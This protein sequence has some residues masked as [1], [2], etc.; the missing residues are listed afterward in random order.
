MDETA[1][2]PPVRHLL[3][4]PPE[5]FTFVATHLGTRDLHSTGR[6][7]HTLHEW[8]VESCRELWRSV[9]PGSKPIGLANETKGS[10]SGS[11][12]HLSLVQLLR[13]HPQHVST[14]SCG[15]SATPGAAARLRA[16]VLL[17]KPE[18][19][20]ESTVENVITALQAY[21]DALI[22]F[23]ES[24]VA[25]LGLRHAPMLSRAN[26][27]EIRRHFVKDFMGEM[28]DEHETTADLHVSTRELLSSYLIRT[29]DADN[30]HTK[31]LRWT[32][33]SRA[34]RPPPHCIG[35][36][37]HESARAAY[38][39]LA[40]VFC[41]GVCPVDDAHFRGALSVARASVH[42]RGVAFQ[43]AAQLPEPDIFTQNTLHNVAV[44]GL[45]GIKGWWR[46]VAV[47]I[48]KCSARVEERDDSIGVMASPRVF[49]VT[50][51][52]ETMDV[53]RPG[54]LVSGLISTRLTKDAPDSPVTRFVDT[55]EVWP[56]WLPSS[57]CASYGDRLV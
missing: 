50:F 49:D 23:T 39:C 16:R 12:T 6:A 57:E 28:V 56:T 41:F 55:V 4:L 44:N 18:L 37:M 53:V 45:E 43:L 2:P 31:L 51:L 20:K 26:R 27:K 25:E 3:D 34:G 13:L 7:S 15:W 35:E 1:L 17:S 52:P 48:S 38:C 30:L 10:L 8:T 36:A 40:A 22:E 54:L 5:M 29:W 33:L 11:E 24:F 32:G 46:I 42:D 9:S 47:D 19:A 21:D 14:S